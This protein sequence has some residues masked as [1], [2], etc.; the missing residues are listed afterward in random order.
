[1][2]P[3]TYSAELLR[4]SN[5]DAFLERECGHWIAA[6][7]GAAPFGDPISSTGSV[8]EGGKAE[9]PLLSLAAVLDGLKS[10]H[11]GRIGGM[12]RQRLHNRLQLFDK[13][14]ATEFWS[15]LAGEG[16]RDW[17]SPRSGRRRI[18]DPISVGKRMLFR[19]AASVEGRPR[20]SATIQFGTSTSS[21]AAFQ[22]GKPA[23]SRRTRKPLAFRSDAAS[24]ES[25]Q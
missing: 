22:S 13:A 18:A 24:E 23:A 11:A 19:R 10:S 5:C 12:G 17:A 16:H 21:P 1:M 20:V 6:A 9:Q 4:S 15:R 7:P 2:A 25:T 3:A 8:F 14:V